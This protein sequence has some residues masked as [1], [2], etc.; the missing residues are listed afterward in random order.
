MVCGLGTQHASSQGQHTS[1]MVQELIEGVVCE[2]MVYV[3]HG[4]VVGFPRLGR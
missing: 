3:I 1:F 2:A 4:E